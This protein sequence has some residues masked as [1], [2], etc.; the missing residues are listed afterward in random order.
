MRVT[1]MQ[2]YKVEDSFDSIYLQRVVKRLASA[3]GFSAA[4]QTRIAISVSELATNIL[5]YSGSGEIIFDVEDT[6]A[7][8]ITARDNGPGIKDL[9]MAFKDHHSDTRC[10]LDDDFKI[11][12]GRGTGLPAVKRLMDECQVV[13]TGK[14]GTVIVIKKFL[15]H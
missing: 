10:L 2:I 11:H 8:T 15:N 12:K 5:K 3:L 4:D 13:S 7:I 14:D 6:N 1:K 9:D